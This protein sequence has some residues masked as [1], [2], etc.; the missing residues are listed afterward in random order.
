MK[1]KRIVVIENINDPVASKIVNSWAR[2]F[3]KHAYKMDILLKWVEA[4]SKQVGITY[5]FEEITWPKK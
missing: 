3:N 4:K 2:E 5:G 1:I